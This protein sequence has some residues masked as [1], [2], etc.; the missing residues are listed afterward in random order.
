MAILV[1]SAG[2]N[3]VAYLRAKGTTAEESHD[4]AIQTKSGSAD[5]CTKVDLANERLVMNGIR[6]RYPNHD[7]IGEE[8]VG[9]G[10]VPEI[11]PSV[12]TWIIDPIDGTTNFSAGLQSLTCVSIGYCEVDLRAEIGRPAFCLDGQVMAFFCGGTL[13]S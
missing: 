4:L 12:P 5:F 7:I 1:L 10:S 11:N 9:T 3:M 6:K 13:C 8:S 2:S